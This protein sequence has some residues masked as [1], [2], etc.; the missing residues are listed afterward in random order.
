MEQKLDMILHQRIPEEVEMMQFL[1]DEECGCGQNQQAPGLKKYEEVDKM[2]ERALDGLAFQKYMALTRMQAMNASIKAC[3][4]RLEN[5]KLE[6]ERLLTY[7]DFLIEKRQEA[8]NYEA[9]LRQEM[10]QKQRLNAMLVKK[11]GQQMKQKNE[12]EDKEEL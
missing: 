5:H 7:A 2:L 10:E 3:N 4:E 1:V 6:D 8:V 11:I 12:D 9:A